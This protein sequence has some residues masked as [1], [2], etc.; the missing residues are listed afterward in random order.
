[1]DANC[2]ES[3]LIAFQVRDAADCLGGLSRFAA[4]A[5]LLRVSVMFAQIRLQLLR[6]EAGIPLHEFSW[7]CLS[8]LFDEKWLG[9]EETN[10]KE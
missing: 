8:D 6:I 1:M 7:L 10:G 3:E 2:A 9:Y 4:F 5:G